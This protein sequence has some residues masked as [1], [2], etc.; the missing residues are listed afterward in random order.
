LDARN[1]VAD[2]QLQALIQEIKEKNDIVSVISEYV[3]LKRTGRSLIGLCPFHSEK[4][5]SFNVNQAEQFYYCFGCSAGGDVFSFIMRLEGLDFIGAARLLADR[6]GIVWPESSGKPEADHDKQ[7]ELYKI[8]QLAMAFFEQ[9][10]Y[11]T[12]D[13]KIALD[14]LKNRGLTLETCHQ[15]HLGFAP[16]GWHLLTEVFRKKEVSL[17]LADSLGLVSFGEKGYYDRFRDRII[18]PITDPKGN[19]IG[20]GGRIFRDSG[21]TGGANQPKYLNSPETPIF[22]KGNFLYGLSLAKEAIR[23][24]QLAI[25]TEGY[26]DVIQAHQGGFDNTVA[27]LGTALTKVQAKMI[28][29]Y[30]TEVILAYDADAA[31]QHATVR[32][33]EILKEAGLMV[34]VLS[35]SPGD[36]PDSFIK[37]K[38]AAEFQKQLETAANLTDFKISLAIKDYNLNTPEGKIQAVHSA[39]PQIAE[40][41]SNIGREFYLRKLSLEIGISETSVFAEFKEWVKKNQKKPIALDK[42][43]DNSYTKKTT[44][45][46]ANTV[47]SFNPAELA[48]FQRA[49]FNT[50]KELLQSVLQEYEK[51]ERIKEELITEEFSFKIWQDL[52][53]ELCSLCGNVHDSE[54]ILAALNGPSREIAATLISEK[55]VKDEPVDLPGN[56]K[57]LRKLKLEETI[58]QLTLQITSH[59][60]E[61]GNVLTEEAYRL[62]LKQFTELN[63]KLRKDF[64]GVSS[65]IK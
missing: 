11:R 14:Y 33:M 61:V 44:E 19:V 10:L 12:E 22:H 23:R 29:R 62:K 17:E 7:A 40:L 13:G 21:G 8:N 20:F 32:G 37:G 25:I 64:S 16:A 1:A 27:S 52:F 18:F 45:K 26:L 59:K 2:D 31:G 5:P 65:G 41:D 36:D 58:Q 30:A 3:T 39:L 42:N 24:K 57:R 49:I 60:D 51:F 28:K 4:T 6:A 56:I 47:D 43:P 46:I 35:L 9:S 55:K 34:K 63:Q 48:P 15:F 50:E 54:Q 53:S 38:G